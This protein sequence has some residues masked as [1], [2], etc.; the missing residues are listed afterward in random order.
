MSLG[1]AVL[2]GL[3]AA[4]QYYDII[5]TQIFPAN[6]IIYAVII[7]ALMGDPLTG[8][9]VGST[10]QLMSLGVAALGGSSVPNYGMVA[11]ISTALTIATGQPVAVGVA[12]GI[13]AGT[14]WVQLDVVV[15][16]VN[17]FI[18]RKSQKYCEEKKFKKMEYTL[19]LCIAVQMPSVFLPTF[20]TCAFGQSVTDFITNYLPGWFTDGLTLATGM[21]PVV[22]MALL[23]GFM[24]TKK[25]LGFVAIGFVLAAYLNL[26]ILPVAIIGAA[27]AYE[28]YKRQAAATTAAVNAGGMD[29]DE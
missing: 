7:G 11:V 8:L 28:Y 5:A 4:I 13:V 27:V 2:V 14:L 26:S 6:Y 15:K 24:P 25:Y 10:V 20:I 19:L 22:G 17:G 23:L 9:V 21:L 3:V 29:E 12:V 1:M 16:I 18:A